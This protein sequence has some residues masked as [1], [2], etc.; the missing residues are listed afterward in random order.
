[1]PQASP[2]VNT[3]T[4]QMQEGLSTRTHA[5]ELLRLM[6]YNVQ[7]GISSSRPHHYLLHSWKHLLPHT[8]RFANIDQLC[9]ELHRYDIVGLQEVDAGSLRSNFINLT[10]YMAHL[11][12]F[13]HWYHQVNRN[14]GHLARHSNGL[15]S[16][17]RPAEIRDIKLPGMIPGRRAIMARFGSEANPLVV[18]VLHLALGKRA[19]MNQLAYLAELINEYPHAIVMG[20]LNT[21]ADSREMLELFRRTRLHEPL[22]EVHTFPSW[23]PR[24]HIDHILVTTDLEVEEIH[25]PALEAYSD[26]LPIAMSIRLPAGLTLSRQSVHA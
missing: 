14:L 22:E 9:H 8:Q 11:A 12:G 10:E 4:T 16:Q 13:S 6:S 21:A 5:D 23:R 3:A 18:F 24:K 25:V 20:D 26:H 7:V 1:M 17:Y 2:R 19:R 15:L